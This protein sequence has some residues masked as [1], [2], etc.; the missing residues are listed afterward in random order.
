MKR[1]EKS[2]FSKIS[3]DVCGWDLSFPRSWKIQVLLLTLYYGNVLI[4][5]EI[6]ANF[7]NLLVTALGLYERKIREE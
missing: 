5:H 4:A 1:R 7:L 6:I 2:P 3:G